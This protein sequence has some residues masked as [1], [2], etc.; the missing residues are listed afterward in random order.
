MD[1]DSVPPLLCDNPTN[2]IENPRR[3]GGFWNFSGFDRDHDPA[4]FAACSDRLAGS[5]AQPVYS[6]L[7]A[8]GCLGPAGSVDPTGPADLVG[9]FD[10]SVP[11]SLSYTPQSC[12]RLE[13]AIRDTGFS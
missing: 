5:A 13:T 9:G 11:F 1:Q 10:R 8:G 4:G 7:P 12:D 2:R 6:G 3:S